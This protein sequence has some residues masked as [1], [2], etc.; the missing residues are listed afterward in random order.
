MQ[1]AKDVQDYYFDRL[2]T[3]DKST[4][5]HFASRMAP[6]TDDPRAVKHLSLLK[7]WMSEPARSVKNFNDYVNETLNQPPPAKINATERRTPYFEKYPQLRSLDFIL[8]KA[9]HLLTLYDMDVRPYLLKSI[10]MD[11][12]TSLGKSL[13][14]DDDA[15]RVLSTY[16]VNFFYLLEILFGESHI[17]IE[18]YLG[19]AKGY[20]LTNSVDLQLY[21]YLYTHCII[22]AS[23]FY[24][25]P[26][27]SRNIP[28]YTKMLEQ[29]ELVIDQNFT[30]IN[31]DNKMEFLVCARIC[32]YDSNL[33]E[34]INEEA[35]LSIS[36]SGTFI[37]D[38]LNSNRQSTKTSLQDS[39]HRNVLFIMAQ[40][41]YP[42]NFTGYQTTSPQ[43]QLSGL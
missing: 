35:Q 23:N 43:S 2:K 26:I 16:A 29:L 6:W 5:F 30:D 41:P 13:A 12:V 28:I 14:R 4:Q 25:R 34:R 21:I 31:L 42:N 3:L 10:D 36:D 8:F 20:N 40:T 39:E 33:L 37:I 15:I 22:G 38:R 11:Q 7:A 32:G 24:V 9:R 1:L 19:I 18:E 17:N 27:A